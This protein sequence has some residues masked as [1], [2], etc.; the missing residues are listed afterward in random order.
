[1]LALL[2]F[3]SLLVNS[4]Q[5]SQYF[6][7][8]TR[9]ITSSTVILVKGNDSDVISAPGISDSER[10]DKNITTQSWKQ[11]IMIVVLDGAIP[12]LCGETSVTASMK[13]GD[14]LH[15]T[16]EEPRPVVHNIPPGYDT[17]RPSSIL[18]LHNN[19]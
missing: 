18:P 3:T 11:I 1:M 12:R 13:S 19:G 17:S 9:N 10:I 15:S 2:V 5:K 14:M 4:A 8:T 7:V 16:Y 6:Q